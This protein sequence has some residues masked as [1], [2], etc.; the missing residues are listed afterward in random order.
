MPQPFE[1][2]EDYLASIPASMRPALEHLRQIVVSAAPDAVESI[3]YGLPTY[4]YRG[5]PLVYFGAAK[6]HCA[7]YGIS[8]DEYMAELAEYDASKGT[9]RF[10][11][12]RPLPDTLIE[13]LI[14]DRLASIEASVLQKAG[15]APVT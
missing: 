12:D 3:S 14:G 7:L 13:K 9:V 6:K 5:R 4:K 15:K 1:S 10:S 8:V 11:P 2:V